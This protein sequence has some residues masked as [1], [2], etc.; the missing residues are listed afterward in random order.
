MLLLVYADLTSDNKVRY[1]ITPSQNMSC[2]EDSCLTLS[3]FAANS[4]SYLDNK[5]DI[6]LFFLPG[7]HSLNIELS[8]AYAHISVTNDGQG[9]GTVFI[10]CVSQS[11][12]FNISETAFASIKGLHLIGCGGNTVT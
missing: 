1:Y 5:T 3:Q 7:N 6:S 9:S 2:P 10:E 4:S 11:G 12:R 8:L